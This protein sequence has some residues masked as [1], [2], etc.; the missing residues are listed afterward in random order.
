M[1]VNASQPSTR[2][3]PEHH[4]FVLVLLDLGLLFNDGMRKLSGCQCRNM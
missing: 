1:D 3:P 2:A 4:G